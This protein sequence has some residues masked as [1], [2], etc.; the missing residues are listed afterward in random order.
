MR[1]VIYFDFVAM[2]KYAM[3]AMM[4][5]RP[6]AANKTKGAREAR[7]R[8]PETSRAVPGKA[9]GKQESAPQTR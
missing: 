7:D 3:V 4:M 2:S 9:V 8:G 6:K 1:M 5:A